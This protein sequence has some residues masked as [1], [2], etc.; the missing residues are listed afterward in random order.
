MSMADNQQPRLRVWDLPTRVFH[1][2][3]ILAV[4]GAVGTALADVMDWHVR[5]GLASGALLLF[6]LVWGLIGGQWS[7]FGSFLRGARGVG[8]TRSGALAII[9][10]LLV[11]LAQVGT[12]LFADD[13]VAT[14]GPLARFVSDAVTT[15]ATGW[16]K[17]FGQWLI[18]GLVALHVIAVLVYTL[19]GHA[20]VA[21]MW[22]GDKRV[23]A[24]AT[25]SASRDDWGLRLLALIVFACCAAG[26]VW[27]ARL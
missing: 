17:G 11:L 1:I 25:W 23:P 2:L 20:L 26:A 22:H 5:F 27:L 7:R 6:R 3:L 15:A 16:H 18:Y 10:M 12:G 14:T 24:G 21:A 4:G 8:H 9:A 13:E 19:R